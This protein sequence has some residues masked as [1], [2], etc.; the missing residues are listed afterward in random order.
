MKQVKKLVKPLT[1]LPLTWADDGGGL[2]S[3][4]ELS[5]LS[6]IRAGVVC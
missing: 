3:V 2:Y 1:V 6:R 4:F 5:S